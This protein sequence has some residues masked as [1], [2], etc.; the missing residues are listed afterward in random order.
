MLK[1]LFLVAIL[2]DL[3]QAVLRIVFKQSVIYSESLPFSPSP[4]HGWIPRPST[5]NLLLFPSGPP[6][7][8][9][10]NSLGHYEKEPDQFGTCTPITVL[11]GETVSLGYELPLS[12]NL[13]RSL[14]FHTTSR[15]F[16]NASVRNYSTSQVVARYIATYDQLPNHDQILFM[17]NLNM[18]R[19][20]ITIHEAGKSTLFT[21]GNHKPLPVIHMSDLVFADANGNVHR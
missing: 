13:S 11:L 14:E 17:F 3:L 4:H 19:R 20:D 21:H 2:G 8:I 10:H 18:P 12:D 7:L 1:T 16:Y 9:T 6:R 5:R 15:N